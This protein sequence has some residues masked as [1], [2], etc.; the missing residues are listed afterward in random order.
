MSRDSVPLLV[1]SV[2]AGPTLRANGSICT[3]VYLIGAILLVFGLGLGFLGGCAQ[4]GGYRALEALSDE[5]VRK[6]VVVAGV[7]MV[8]L[9]PL[10]QQAR[11]ALVVYI[12]GDGRAWASRR[13]PS[14]NPTP[15][16]AVALALAQH[17]APSARL[18]LGR[19]C[20]YLLQP[21]PGQCESEIW[22]NSRY[23]PDNV[24]RLSG[25][26]DTYLSENQWLLSE[27]QWLQAPDIYL[28]GFSGGGVMA[29]LLADLRPDIAGVI[30]VA[31]NLDVAGWADWH[32]VSPLTNSL[33]P[34][35]SAATLSSIPQIHWRG[36]NDTIVPVEAQR[37]YLNGLAANAVVEVKII[38]G[39]DHSCCWSENWPRMLR[40]SLDFLGFA[41]RAE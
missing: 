41:D 20:Q 36:E 40:E 38:K 26:L 19:P 8:T 29:L 12:E 31:G 15:D 2:I 28:V 13:T 37:G 7:P 24:R 22:T 18:Y 1:D 3:K 23:S 16:N 33:N 35:D 6:D 34:R 14:K 25:A 4:P 21:L 27:N 17:S 10:S 39:V 30:T 5:W 9:A 32:Q 11:G